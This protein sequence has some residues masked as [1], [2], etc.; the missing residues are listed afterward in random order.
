MPDLDKRITNSTAA[1]LPVPAEGYVIY[2]CPKTP[3]FG[4]R[5]SKT[6]DRA[7]VAQ[8]RVEGQTV[9]RTLGKASGAGAVSADSAR[10]ELIKV[11]SKLQEGRDP[12][13]EKRERREAK[14]ADAVTLE[15]ALRAYVKGKRR[16]KDAK[17]LKARTQ[18]DYLAMI[19]PAGT[20][21]TGKPTLPGALHDLAAKPLHRMTAENIRALHAAL[22]DRGERQ[23]TY[24][25][26]VLRAARQK[27]S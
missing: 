3:G 10:R 25:M 14:A 22:V 21:K 19:E 24:A 11:S 15:S 16:A 17:P 27:R 2:W 13:K 8:R 18:A 7:Y 12:L 9:R 26:Q 5:V 1:R 20:T 23:Q 4:V 6:G